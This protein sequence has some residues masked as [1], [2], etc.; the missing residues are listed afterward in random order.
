MKRRTFV[1]GLLGGLAG[2]AA[3][4]N[5][6]EYVSSGKGDFQWS[7]QSETQAGEVKIVTLKV[8]SQTW[9]GLPWEHSVQIFLPNKIT[10]AKTALLLITGDGPGPNET[11]LGAAIA[12]RLEA[13]AVILYNVPNQPL[14]GGKR[15]DDLI[16]HTFQEFLES[17][18]DTWPLLFP[19][20]KSAVAAMDAAQEFSR[21]DL[22][23]AIEDFVVT[24]ASKRG[25]TTYLTAATDPRVR[26]LA[27]IVFDNL[28]FNKQMPRQL[29][30]W[31]KYSEQIEDYTRRGL[32]QKIDAPS[33]KKLVSMV[34][35]WYYRADLKQPKLLIHGAN[36]R[37]WATDATSLYWNDLPD[38]KYLLAVPNAGHGISDRERVLNTM[39][40]FFHASAANRKLPRLD[41][42]YEQRNGKV[43]I[44]VTASEEPSGVR[45]WSA[46][47]ADMDFRPA[48]FESGTEVLGA[49]KERRAELPVEPSGLAL[50]TEA[51][52]EQAGRTFTLTTVPR[53]YG[54]RG[55]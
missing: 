15:E 43:E 34:D 45:V 11:V 40:A 31:G 47:A 28:N 37:Y 35:P 52:F 41:A 16:A 2:S 10:H 36:D 51:Q 5:L 4:A 27:P 29:A 50:Y 23:Q 14:L 33:G 55:G 18:D 30:L 38:P 1:A 54:T 7:K 3:W 9:R 21:K 46:R 49:G 6:R 8:R 25:W 20:V 39:T 24:G 26:A 12:P 44:R 13:P 53:V 19:M 42:K 48:R 17:G 32:Q 22:G